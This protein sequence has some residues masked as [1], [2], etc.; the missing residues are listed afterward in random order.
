MQR[1]E[2][3]LRAFLASEPASNAD[4]ANLP[5]LAGCSRL[6]S[7]RGHSDCGQGPASVFL[8]GLGFRYGICLS[9]SRV[10]QQRDGAAP[11]PILVT[12]SQEAVYDVELRLRRYAH[13][14]G[15]RLRLSCGPAGAQKAR[16][17]HRRLVGTDRRARPHRQARSRWAS[18]P[19]STRSMR[20]AACS[21][22]KL[23]VIAYDDQGEAVTRG[24]QRTPHRRARQLH[25]HDRRLSHA[26]C[27]RHPHRARRNGPAL[28]GRDLGRH[29]RDRV[30]DRQERVDVPRLGERPLG[31]AVPGRARLAAQQDQEDRL[32]VR[33]HRL[34]PGRRARH[35]GGHEGQGRARSSAR[36]RSTSATRT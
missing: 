15:R 29:P 36:R 23:R 34:G 27:A 26:E 12:T 1:I 31:G 6:G 17:L 3:S 22:K 16:A 24:R 25:H 9:E 8:T 13:L 10:E 30:G 5:R 4:R 7:Q 11:T 28:D 18:R 33:G 14:P 20:P 19:P 32:H 35:R 2:P 21:G